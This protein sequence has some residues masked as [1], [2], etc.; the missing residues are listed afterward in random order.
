MQPLRA[1]AA[2]G[3]FRSPGLSWTRL[4]SR[5]GQQPCAA[6]C[7]V[8][9]V[10]A[11]H[12]GVCVSA[13]I[14]PGV[15]ACRT[16]PHTTTA[17]QAQ[18]AERVAHV[19]TAWLHARELQS[20]TRVPHMLAKLSTGVGREPGSALTAASRRSTP[21]RASRRGAR[22]LCTNLPRRIKTKHPRGCMHED[23]LSVERAPGPLPFPPVLSPV[24]LDAAAR[25]E[26][27]LREPPLRPARNAHVLEHFPQRVR[28]LVESQL[29]STHV[30]PS[31]R[32]SSNLALALI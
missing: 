26:V 31:F 9:R 5:K 14:A 25:I 27:A 13:C 8:C 1:R 24:V 18:P 32:T 15:P 17:H 12:A 29:H 11:A 2:A 20:I 23:A 21:T 16:T 7:I 22:K 3:I 6:P 10:Q 30:A 19:D 28:L 4:G